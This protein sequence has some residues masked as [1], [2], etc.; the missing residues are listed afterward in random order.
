VWGL[1]R[2]GVRRGDHV[3]VWMENR[4]E[5]VALEMAVTSLGAV[6]VPV[7]T[8]YRSA[9]AEYLLQQSD[10][11]TLV[12]TDR[13][14]GIDFTAT[15]LELAPELE[16]AAPGALDAARLPRLRRVVCLG[17]ARA[18]G[19]VPFDTLTAE[20]PDPA[21]LATLRGAVG[22]DD[23]ALI[24]YTSGTTAFPK[25]VMLTHGQ[26]TR[27]MYEARVVEEELTPDDRLLVVAP[28]F[29]V[30]GG[31]NSVVGMLHAGGCLV[32]LDRFDP[33]LV[34]A[35]IARE[36][37][38]RFYGA[39]AMFVDMME[40]GV[41]SHHDLRS[42]RRISVF[43]GPFRTEFLA[44]LLRSLGAEGVSVGYGLTETTNG[45]TFVASWR[46]GLDR[47]ARTVGRPPPYYEVAIFD[48]ATGAPLPAEAEGE[49]RV[50]GFVVMKGYYE[51][52]EETA[53]AVDADG[54][55]HT[56]D[57][58]AFDRE[59]YLH[60][61]GRLKDMLKTS[62][63]NVSC[64]EVE[65]VLAQHPA[66]MEAALVGIPDR[67]ATEVGA[68]FVRLR[69]GARCTEAEIVRF[70]R[71][72]LARFKVPAHVCFVNEFPRSSSDKV[73]KFV[74]RDTLVAELG[75]VTDAP[76]GETP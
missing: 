76:R 10:A 48:P 59:G 38:T 8:R 19:I 32:V 3:A 2:L 67:R 22:P 53:R 63:F 29:H 54:W 6:A 56:G 51:K 37:V 34:A 20:P 21:T 5:W 60:F 30:V 52:P 47:V 15:V 27:N 75:L 69:E 11:D 66:V 61:R 65:S 18:R 50:R 72:R 7:N 49:I 31:T 39:T 73:R 14:L 42:L 16:A 45:A 26:I 12:Y 68:A 13:F 4:P 33:E 17:P 40:S 64:Q 57:L 24:I 71:D 70:C 25:G 1:H 44:E 41:L 9:E 28:F 62:G 55:L 35:T 23:V 74:L 46:D 58:G 43:P 36:R